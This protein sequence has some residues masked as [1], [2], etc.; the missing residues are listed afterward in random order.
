MTLYK[1]NLGQLGEQKAINFL[2]NNGFGILKK[3][4]RSYGGE[5][6]IIAKKNRCIYF[7]E[8]KTRTNLNKGQ[9][10][11]SVNKR[12]IYSIKKAADY[13]LLK[14]RFKDYKL[15]LAIISLVTGNGSEKLKFYEDTEGR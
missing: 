8:V 12:K 15:R 1:R 5:I 6:D 3:N 14:Y 2:K 13:F 7:I 9:P 10:W 11:E 4:F